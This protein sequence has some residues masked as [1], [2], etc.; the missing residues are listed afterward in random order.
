M[1][2]KFDSSYVGSVDLENPGYGGT[3]INDRH[4]PNQELAST[5]HLN[6]FDPYNEDELSHLIFR[7]WQD[8][9]IGA[10]QAAHNRAAVCQYSWENAALKY[11]ELFSR[12]ASSA[13]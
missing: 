5:M 3:P 2:T 11:L 9:E 4:Y 6:L 12:I 8:N 7:L 1:I 13:A 10:R